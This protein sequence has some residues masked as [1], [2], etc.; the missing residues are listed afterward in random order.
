MT[1]FSLMAGFLWG[2][3]PQIQKPAER[4]ED[5]DHQHHGKNGNNA[6]D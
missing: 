4:N 2:D 6:E 5:K 1:F 3:N